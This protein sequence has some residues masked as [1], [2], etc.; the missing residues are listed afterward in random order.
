M[1]DARHFEV[2]KVPYKCLAVYPLLQPLFIYL[3]LV[4]RPEIVKGPLNT[5]FTA[6]ILF[7]ASLFQGA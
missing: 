2:Q 1:N 5:G 6:S 4:Q 3:F 7:N